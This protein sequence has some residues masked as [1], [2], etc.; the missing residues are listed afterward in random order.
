MVKQSPRT[1]KLLE[2]IENNA[3]VK[4]VMNAI[5]LDVLSTINM[6]AFDETAKQNTGSARVEFC[7]SNYYRA[8]WNLARMG[9]SKNVQ[10]SGC[11]LH[12]HVFEVLRCG[13]IR[14]RCFV[15]MNLLC[16]ECKSH[17][18]TWVM[19]NAKHYRQS[20]LNMKVVDRYACILNGHRYINSYSVRKLLSNQDTLD[21]TQVRV[22]RTSENG[23][24]FR[25]HSK[26]V[27]PQIS[28]RENRCMLLQRRVQKGQ[29]LPGLL[30]WMTGHMHWELKN[31]NGDLQRAKA[32]GNALICG[33][34][35]HTDLLLT[36][37][38][39]F[40]SYNMEALTLV[41]IVWLVGSDHHTPC[42]VLLAARMHGLDYSCDDAILAS[43]K[44]LQRL[45]TGAGAKAE[46]QIGP[47]REET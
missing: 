44:M 7:S 1:M 17:V 36:F 37:C 25:L 21:R 34:S 27:V 13:N 9:T 28:R 31:V 29:E 10:D 38:K 12:R 42:E 3:E 6:I 5:S 19:Q 23:E 18:F 22:Q 32:S 20:V 35:G 46:V 26:D 41:A 14:E 39:I 16:K 30:P 43:Y 11:V 45:S 33:I 8:L 4:A 24:N 40:H 47:S 15:I 2:A